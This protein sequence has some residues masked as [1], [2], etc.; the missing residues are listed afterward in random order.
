MRR[1]VQ[2]SMAQ[3]TLTIL[4]RRL[5]IETAEDHIVRC[6]ERQ[7]DNIPRRR[8]GRCRAHEDGLR[9]TALARDEKPACARVYKREE[10]RLLR[11][12]LSDDSCKRVARIS[13]MLLLTPTHHPPPSSRLPPP[14]KDGGAGGAR[15]R[16]D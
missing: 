13:R 14:R 4:K 16:G 6:P 11:L 8:K 3:A 9:R 2:E 7:L 5:H 1:T 12:L 15:A 10:K